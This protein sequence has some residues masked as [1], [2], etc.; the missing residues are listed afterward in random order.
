[1]E[2]LKAK[3]EQLEGTVME[4][5]FE[6]TSKNQAYDFLKKEKESLTKQ[7]EVLKTN[8]HKDE[9]KIENIVN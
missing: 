3:V 2:E 7:I 1:M 8:M 4:R 9:F 5:E 6:L